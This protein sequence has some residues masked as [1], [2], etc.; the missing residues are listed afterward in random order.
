MDDFTLSIIATNKIFYE[1]KSKSLIVP[2]STGERGILAHHAGMLCAINMG[3]LRF[4]DE[5]GTWRSILVGAG[6]LIVN[7][8]KVLV[9]VDTVETLEEIDIDRAE[10]AMQRAQE[11]MLQKQ[12]KRQYLMSQAAMARALSRLRYK[13]KNH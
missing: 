6:S 1:G 7:N 12:S 4:M 5:E 9:L 3:E 10:Q 13:D 8:N 2:T 11:R